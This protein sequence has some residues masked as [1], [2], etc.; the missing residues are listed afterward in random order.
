VVSPCR[1]NVKPT[2]HFKSPGRIISDALP[3]DCGISVVKRL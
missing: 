3:T 2:L 1:S